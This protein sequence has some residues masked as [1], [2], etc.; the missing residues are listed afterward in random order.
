[1]MAKMEDSNRTGIR[2]DLNGKQIPDEIASVSSIRNDKESVEISF[3]CLL[4]MLEEAISSRRLWID[5]F[6][7][8][9]VQV[10]SD[11]FDVIQAFRY[12]NPQ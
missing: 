7:D 8:E 4:P 2:F 5:D 10:S 3:G 9:P 1:M 6:S 11:L 12:F